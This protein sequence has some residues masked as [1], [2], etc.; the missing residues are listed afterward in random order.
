MWSSQRWRRVKTNIKNGTYKN[1]S[2]AQTSKQRG[3]CL[4]GEFGRR[5]DFNFK[6]DVP[7]V[8][9]LI[10]FAMMGFKS[11]FKLSNFGLNYY[12]ADVFY[13]MEVGGTV[14]T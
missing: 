9:Y 2:I 13:Q 12:N 4:E 11:E 10:S 7:L 6:T 5:L 1:G 3:F 14:K 8:I